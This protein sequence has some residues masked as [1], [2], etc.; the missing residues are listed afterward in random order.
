MFVGENV[1][2]VQAFHLCCALLIFVI[3]NSVTNK[4]L[5]VQLPRDRL[6][7]DT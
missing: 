6:C 1:V 4:I 3:Y 2:G 7:S 5:C